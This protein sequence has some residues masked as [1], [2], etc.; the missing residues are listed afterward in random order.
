MI[1]QDGKRREKRA[2]GHLGKSLRGW[3]PPFRPINIA[4]VGPRQGGGG[5]VEA[6]REREREGCLVGALVALER[7]RTVMAP[8]T[9]ASRAVQRRRTATP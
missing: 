1:R 3:M 6:A 8:R 5:R 4:L 9:A 7:Q 2:A